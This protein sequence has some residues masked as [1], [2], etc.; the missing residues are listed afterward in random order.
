MKDKKR[1]PNLR[2]CKIRIN[3]QKFE[4]IRMSLPVYGFEQFQHC[5]N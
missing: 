5:L 4:S 1:T 2:K 3:V